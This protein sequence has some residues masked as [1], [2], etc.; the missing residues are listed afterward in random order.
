MLSGWLLASDEE[1]QQDSALKPQACVL[2]SELRTESG[3]LDE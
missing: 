3:E 2:V 1:R